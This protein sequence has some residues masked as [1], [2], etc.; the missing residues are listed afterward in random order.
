MGRTGSGRALRLY[1]DA[2]HGGKDPGVIG[3]GGLREADLTV[4]VAGRV[5]AM[6]MAS[7]WEIQLS[8]SGSEGVSLASRAVSA[9][10]WGADLFVSIHGNGAVN[11]TA[12]GFEVWTS[13]GQTE[14]DEVA[15]AMAKTWR[16]S[17][18]VDVMRC[19]LS[20][21]DLDKE[22]PFYVL[23]HTRCRAV[24]VEV[25]FVSN[26]ASEKLL[27]TPSHRAAIARAIVDGINAW[28]ASR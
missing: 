17:F 12:H 10:A 11:P 15:E 14:S 21:G 19:D 13:P 7:G 2:G 6:A 3:P 1:I 18:P 27:A 4:D 22:S 20:D 28:R 9:N 16:V 5:A 25:G 24:L 8:R 26:P 23:V